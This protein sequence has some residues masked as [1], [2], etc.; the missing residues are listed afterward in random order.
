M[1]IFG[2]S[3]RADDIKRSN[4]RSNFVGLA[5]VIASTKHTVELA[6]EPRPWHKILRLR[7]SLTIS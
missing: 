6:A 7:A 4:K 2:V 1:S 3:L 5:E